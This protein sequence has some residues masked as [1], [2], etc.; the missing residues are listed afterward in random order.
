VAHASA[1]VRTVTRGR[2]RRGAGPGTALARD[3]DG[4]AANGSDAA[5][6]Q[7]A[8]AETLND[9]GGV[10]LDATAAAA[11]E[12][13]LAACAERRRA[14]DAR[15]AQGGDDRIAQQLEDAR[16][17][18]VKVGWLDEQHWGQLEPLHTRDAADAF[19]DAVD[20][21]EVDGADG[22]GM[23]PRFVHELPWSLSGTD[24]LDPPAAAAPAAQATEG[25]AGDGG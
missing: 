15:I 21:D 16:P 8:L 17:G 9:F 23:D 18:L 4:G 19:G 11:I 24:M 14:G 6:R 13:A 10:T 1:T 25:A 5:A 22:T 3:G 12:A 20:F 7:D 2:G